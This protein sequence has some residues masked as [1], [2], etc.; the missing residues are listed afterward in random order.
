M[1]FKFQIR[2]FKNFIILL[3]IEIC[4][5][6]FIHDRIIRPF[7]GDALVIWLMVYFFRSFLIIKKQTW[8]IAA[9]FSFACLV[10]IAQYFNILALLKLEGNRFLFIIF[11]ATFDWLDIL[12]YA[13]GSGLLLLVMQM[14]PNRG[15]DND[16][17]HLFRC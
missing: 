13:V 10:E 14:S 5:A 8:L 17:I 16:K 12:A 11:G 7:I 2:N 15:V 6:L 1:S 9:V 3:G 4:I